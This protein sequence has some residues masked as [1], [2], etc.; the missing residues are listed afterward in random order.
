MLPTVN[1]LHS[2]KYSLLINDFP[3]VPAIYNELFELYTRSIIIPE[4]SIEFSKSEFM[5]YK[6]LNPISHKINDL[7]PP[8]LIEFKLLENAYNY[9]ILFNW[10]KRIKY[11]EGITT[12]KIKDYNAII[13]VNILSNQKNVVGKFKFSGC[14]CN[15]ISQLKFNNGTDDEISFDTSFLYNKVEFN[16]VDSD[17]ILN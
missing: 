15:N 8:L 2:S 13:T 1:I 12:D 9:S 10:I 17:L 7:L 3:N 5:G 6:V 16:L 14:F 4:Y 11:G